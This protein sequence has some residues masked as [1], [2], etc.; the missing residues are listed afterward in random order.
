MIVVADTSVV[1][2]LCRVQHERLLQQLFRRVLIPEEVAG[3][4]VRLTKINKRF[5]GLM[6]PDWIE[7]L[8]APK[9]LPIEVIRAELDADEA[10]AIA[11]FLNQKAEALLMDESLGRSVAEKLGIRTM[12]IVRILIDARDRELISNVRLLLDRLHTEANF[13]MAPELKSRVLQMV[14][15]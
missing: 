3:G 2:N 7:V 10:A 12:G 13:W 5:S 15:E 1:L 11:L 14:G 8:S 4:F 6:L 9:S